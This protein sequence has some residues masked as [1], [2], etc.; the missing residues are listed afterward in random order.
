MT[1][2]RAKRKL[3]A[4]LS[5]DVKGYSS[6]MEDDDE[7]TIRAITSY[8]EVVR[9]LIN[10]HNGRVVDA[11]GDNVLAEFLSVVD[12]VRCAVE[13]QKELKVRNADLP[14]HRRMEFRIGINLGDVIEEEETIYRD[15]VNIAA[16]IEGLADGG[17]VCISG[18]VHHHVKNKLS[19]R[20]EYLGEQ[21]VKNITEP[22]GVYKVLI[23]PEAFP[24]ETR[25]EKMFRLK[26]WRRIALVLLI[27]SGLI[28]GLAGLVLGIFWGAQKASDYLSRVPEAIE[29][30]KDLQ[31]QNIAERL[32]EPNLRHTKEI[33]QH[34]LKKAHADSS[35]RLINEAKRK[36][37]MFGINALGPLHKRREQ[38]IRL[39]N[40]GGELQILLLDMKSEAFRQREISEGQRPSDGKIS[41]RLRAE[42]KAALEIIKD[43]NMFKKAGSLELRVYDQSPAF[44]MLIVDNKSMLYNVY[45][46]TKDPVDPADV[47]V[48]RG[49]EGVT[50][51]FRDGEELFHQK[52]QEFTYLWDRARPVDL[53]SDSI[54]SRYE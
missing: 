52:V 33:L 12:A 11:K 24:S 34:N 18:T 44:S 8:R 4:I 50:M 14:E 2:E 5:A 54:E 45:P 53:G 35:I 38:F 51:E 20:Y 39:L 37:Q 9:E 6:L 42:S 32:L 27:V 10:V 49:T 3:A 16:R 22:I 13:I 31:P 1:E 28:I 30:K 19:L 43:L 46:I 17:G 25:L 7:A 26:K 15:G 48:S 29:N 36:V 40:Q 47:A 41:G 21:T 23:K